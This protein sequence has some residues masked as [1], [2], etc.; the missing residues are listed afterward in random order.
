V[1][2]AC[3]N[4]RRR[5]RPTRAAYVALLLLL[6]ACGDAGRRSPQPGALE[7]FGDVDAF[8]TGLGIGGAVPP[9]TPASARGAERIDVG[10]A[11][12]PLL[13]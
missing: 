13:P 1:P 2:T 6:G 10:I 12:L 8:L 5:G 11:G 4:A 3:P 7:P 9:F